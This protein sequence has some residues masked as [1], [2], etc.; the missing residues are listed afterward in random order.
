MWWGS[1]LMGIAR[2]F[3]GRRLAAAI[4]RS[5]WGLLDGGDHHVGGLALEE[6]LHVLDGAQEAVANHLGRL[7]GV[8]GRADDVRQAQDGIV[9]GQGLLVEHV[10]AS[11]EEPA[12]AQRGDQRVAL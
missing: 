9:G 6:A 2:A 4:R 7:S 11:A 3:P 12:L 10:E 1:V 8:V 5:R